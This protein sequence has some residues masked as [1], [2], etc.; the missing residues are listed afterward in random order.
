MNF[1]KKL[2]PLMEMGVVFHIKV[3]QAG[4]QV[5]LDII[6]VAKENKAGVRL[7]AQSIVAT[8]DEIDQNLETFLTGYL[9]ATSNLQSMIAESEKMLEA[10]QAAAKEQIAEAAKSTKNAPPKRRGPS[11]KASPSIDDLD[12]ED[13]AEAEN[14]TAP[15]PGDNPLGESDQ[16]AVNATSKEPS[17]GSLN[18][19]LFV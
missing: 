19:S 1:I 14:Q 5:Q 8:A 18:A 3:S 16:A 6:P 17:D 11:A 2:A 9:N 15:E 10:A 13:E 7:K 12:A 4:D